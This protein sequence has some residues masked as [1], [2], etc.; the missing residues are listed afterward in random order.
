MTSRVPSLLIG[1][2]IVGSRRKPAVRRTSEARKKCPEMRLCRPTMRSVGA[3]V[4]VVEDEPNIGA[5]V[6]TYLQRE[7][8]QTLCVRSGEDA[9]VELRRHPIKLVVLDL[10]LPGIDGFDVCRRIDGRVPIIMLT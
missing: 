10:G 1:D 6:R 9:L 8:F 7:G 4:M 2:R 5:L 3:M